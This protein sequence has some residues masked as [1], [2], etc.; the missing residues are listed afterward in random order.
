M[1]ANGK[2]MKEVHQNSIFRNPLIL[3]TTQPLEEPSTVPQKTLSINPEPLDV[4][5]T[6]SSTIPDPDSLKPSAVAQLRNN[7]KSNAVNSSK[8]DRGKT[9]SSVLQDLSVAGLLKSLDKFGSI[10]SIP[11]TII[12]K[13]N[14][15]KLR[16]CLDLVDFAGNEFDMDILRDGKKA[17]GPSVQ[18]AASRITSTVLDKMYELE[19]TTQV[20]MCQEKL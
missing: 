6:M 12:S 4:T 1:C 16:A 8:G 14:V 3:V 15:S 10:A 11:E 17:F 18:D 19:G 20:A 13:V 7:N 5:S 2:E 9:L